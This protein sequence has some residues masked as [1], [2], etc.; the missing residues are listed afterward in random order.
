MMRDNR[1]RVGDV[2]RSLGGI[3]VTPPVDPDYIRRYFGEL[4]GFPKIDEMITI[5]SGGVPVIAPPSQADLESALR[6]GNH[7]SAEEH[8]PLIWEKVG[9]DVRREKCL[10]LENTAAYE[11][12]N[13]R[14]LPLGAVVTH[15]VRVV[16]DLSLDLFNRAKKGGLN[17][18]TDI[19]CVPLSLCA[20]ALSK[21]LTELVSLKAENPKLRLLMATTDVNDAYHNVIIDPNQAYNFCYTVGDLVVIDFKLTFG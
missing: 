17:A 5:V 13:V 21:F 2:A 20:E 1:G 18:E 15:K 16:N 7:R 3:L 14:V 11:I 10:V 19:N 4:K 8:L 9:E 6:Y 12:P